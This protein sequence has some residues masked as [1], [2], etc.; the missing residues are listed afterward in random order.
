MLWVTLTRACRNLV[1]INWDI[2]SGLQ[3]LVARVF[4]F[5]LF[6]LLLLMLARQMSR[7]PTPQL[8]RQR[9]FAGHKTDGGRR[10]IFAE[11][12][13]DHPFETQILRS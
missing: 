2:R 5:D 13:D 4:V 3:F 9:K 11:I 10:R 6:L 1:G 7:F 8:G 12:R